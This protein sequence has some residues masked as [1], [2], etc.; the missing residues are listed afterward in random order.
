MAGSS[1]HPKV[2]VKH[3]SKYKTNVKYG[4]QHRLWNQTTGI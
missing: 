1:S 3:N 4:R 2:N